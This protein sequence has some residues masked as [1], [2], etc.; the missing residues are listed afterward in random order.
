MLACLLY[1][2]KEV[3]VQGIPTGTDDNATLTCKTR[4]TPKIKRIIL[5]NNKIEQASA[6]RS[7]QEY[8]IQ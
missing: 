6:Q 1:L 4:T 8:E 2:E 7:M 3:T 5:I